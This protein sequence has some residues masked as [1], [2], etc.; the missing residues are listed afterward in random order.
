MNSKIKIIFF[1]TLIFSF[2][3][4]AGGALDETLERAEAALLSGK[5]AM[6]LSLLN[7]RYLKTQSKTEKVILKKKVISFSSIFLTEKGQKAYESSRSHF[8]A[9]LDKAFL[10]VSESKGLEPFKYQCG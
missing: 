7:D 1:S 6:A 3:Y 5:R 10:L 2:R 9:E 8:P 4:S